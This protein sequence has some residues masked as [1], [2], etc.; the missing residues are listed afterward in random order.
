MFPSVVT[1]HFLFFI[2]FCF[3]MRDDRRQ[4]KKK[5]LI[6]RDTF[7]SHCSQR[8]FSVQPEKHLEIFFSFFFSFFNNSFNVQVNDKNNVFFFKRKNLFDSHEFVDLMKDKYRVKSTWKQPNIVFLYLSLVVSTDLSL[9]KNWNGKTLNWSNR[10][11]NYMSNLCLFYSYL[12][13]FVF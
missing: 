7:F 8:F 2:Y 1:R 11:V 5:C 4:G 9:M 10:A 3:D 12:L 6:E 13:F